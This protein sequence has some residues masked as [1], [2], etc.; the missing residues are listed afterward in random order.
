MFQLEGTY[1]KTGQPVLGMGETWRHMLA[2]CVLEVTG[3]E[4]KEAYSKEQL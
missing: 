1:L 3:E 2:K 4:E